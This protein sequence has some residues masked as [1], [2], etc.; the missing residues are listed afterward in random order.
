MKLTE[1]AD[2]TFA[3][4]YADNTAPEISTAN[5][6]LIFPLGTPGNVGIGTPNPTK[7]LDIHG[8]LNDLVLT[9][10]NQSGNKNWCGLRLDRYASEKWFIGMGDGNTSDKLL[11]RRSGSSN[12]VVID[13][14]GHVGIGTA[15]PGYSLE[16]NG[17]A[18]KAAGGAYWVAS[19]DRRLKDVKGEYTHG[20]DQIIKLK[21]VIFYYKA[22]N[23]RGLL[24]NEE[25]VGFVAQ[26]VQ[27][28]FP[29]AVAEGRDG[30]LNLNM[31]PVN[32]ALVNAVKELKAENDALKKEI[33]EIRAILA[34]VY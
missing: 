5:A 1:T 33:E 16:V 8:K 22:G 10:L 14:S 26:E 20:L 29:E 4:G 30:Y 19:S 6:F 3:W 28:V 9:R 17:N 32:V 27:A 12:D 24:P 13:E 25:N 21:P 34:T 18:A 7:K 11:F 15:N 23:S 31:Q 2:H